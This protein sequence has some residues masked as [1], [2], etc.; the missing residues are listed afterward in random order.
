MLLL[1]IFSIYLASS[2]TVDAYC[3]YGTEYKNA[4]GC[5][6]FFHT[7]LN[8]TN[9]V[10]FC[11]VNMKSTLVRPVSFI[12]NQQLQQAA[13]KLGIEEYW[14]GASNVDNDWEWLDGSMLTY[15]N[16][17]VL[18]GYP[19]KT[20]SQIGAVSMGSLSGL[21]YTKHDSM[22]LPFVCEFPLSNQYD[23][24]ILYRAPKL[25]SLIF[26]SAGTKAPMLMVDSV[27][28]SVLF[29]KIGPKKNE[30]ETGEK[31]Y[32]KP[33][34]ISTAGMSGFEG[35]PIVML[36][37]FKR[38]IKVKPVIVSQTE[39]ELARSLKEKEEV[40]DSVNLKSVKTGGVGNGGNGT[41]LSEELNS[42]S[43]AKREREESELLRSKTIQISRG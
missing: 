41:S 31:V 5:F 39:T 6:Q 18:G 14:I 15:S 40:E 37:T 10:R 23:N 25:Q 16:F 2:I 22:M 42:N 33:I 32:L 36:N 19:K 29:E 24:G 21:W 11:R 34:N 30:M 27:D 13:I 1:F 43:K 20:E 4:T 38:K 26:P 8:F 9:A 12:R 17:D 28:Q 7:P 35:Q 3:E